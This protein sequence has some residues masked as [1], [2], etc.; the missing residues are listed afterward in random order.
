LTREQR[1]KW[2]CYRLV[3]GAS[4]ALAALITSTEV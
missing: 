1:A 2:A 4:D 3:P